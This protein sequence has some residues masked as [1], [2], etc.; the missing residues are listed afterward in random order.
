MV[1]PPCDPNQ[2]HD[3]AA[4]AALIGRSPW[5]LVKDR[6]LNKGI[7]YIRI[8]RSI[9]YRASDIAKFLDANTVIPGKP[10][11]PVKDPAHVQVQNQRPIPP[12]LRGLRGFR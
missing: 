10:E 1:F 11:Q 7:P 6:R 9:R 4:T 2:L 12:H 3:T 8:G 5:T